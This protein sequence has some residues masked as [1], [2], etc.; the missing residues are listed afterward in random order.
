MHAYNCS[1]SQVT[2]GVR[3][4]IMVYDRYTNIIFKLF[5]RTGHT[6]SVERCLTIIPDLRK[7]PDPSIPLPWLTVLTMF[8][9]ALHIEK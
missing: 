3:H 5:S 8:T 9:Q 4:G 1:Y 7:V 6:S 2:G